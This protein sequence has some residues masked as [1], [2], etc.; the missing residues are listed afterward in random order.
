[1]TDAENERDRRI[2][3]LMAQIERLT[4]QGPLI[5]NTPQQTLSQPKSKAAKML[6][7]GNDCESAGVQLLRDLQG[8]FKER[9]RDKI[10]STD[11][12]EALAKMAERPWAEWK[13]GKP[14]TTRQ[15]ARLLKQFDIAPG[16]FRVGETTHRGY[17]KD[18]CIDTFTRLVDRSVT[19]ERNITIQIVTENSDVTDRACRPVN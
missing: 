9:N 8:L 7:V 6:T 2:D 16:V 1:M 15:V 4:G 11:L 3:D 10:T 17:N 19:P 12:V 14:I 18:D 5:R 13:K